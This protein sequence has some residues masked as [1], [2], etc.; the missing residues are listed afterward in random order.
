MD[1]EKMEM[2]LKTILIKWEIEIAWGSQ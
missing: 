2:K 1:G